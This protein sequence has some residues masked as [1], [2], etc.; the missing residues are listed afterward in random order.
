[1]TDRDFCTA[2]KL[3]GD[4]I[5]NSI[6]HLDL[7]W[8]DIEIQIDEMREFCRNNAPDKLPLFEMLYVSRFKNLWD[9]W[10]YHWKVEGLPEQDSLYWMDV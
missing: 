7:D 9:A 10:G 4:R 6:L 8:V 2:L 5:S 3:Y 1:M